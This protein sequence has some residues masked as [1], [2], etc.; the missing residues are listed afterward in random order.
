MN[1]S[2]FQ[3][4]TEGEEDWDEAVYLDVGSRVIIDGLAHPKA[5]KYNN[6]YG[7]LSGWVEEHAR[8]LVHMDLDN[9]EKELK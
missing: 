4:A 2:S 1:Y 6:T 9:S 8:W 5:A 7:T 3:F